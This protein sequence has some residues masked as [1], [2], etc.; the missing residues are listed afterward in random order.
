MRSDSHTLDV[1]VL[2]KEYR[3]A[4]PP[5]EKE[6]LLASVAYL[7]GKMQELAEL[8]KSSGERL[9][10]MT[11][12]NITHELLQMRAA[13][14]IDVAGIKRRIEAMQARIEEALSQQEQ[15]F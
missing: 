1:V 15:L 3:V 7:D 4:C 9:T 5:G 13:S 14:S 12:L 8:T 11:A 2:G 6:Q 10:V